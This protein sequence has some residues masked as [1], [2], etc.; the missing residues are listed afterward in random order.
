MYLTRLP[1]HPKCAMS[2]WGCEEIKVHTSLVCG[3]FKDDSAET[4]EDID[5]IWLSV[6]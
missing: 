6:N 3:L 5:G 2:L 1:T 4:L